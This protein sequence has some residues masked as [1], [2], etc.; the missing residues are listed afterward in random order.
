[1]AR[2]IERGKGLVSR[3]DIVNALIVG[4]LILLPLLS[5][6]SGAAGAALSADDRKCLSCHAT[7][8]LAKNLANGENLPLHV[9]QDGFAKSVHANL[10]C[11]G[12]HYAIDL[13]SH[14]PGKQDVK[15]IRAYSVELSE[16]C[17]AC[18][19]GKFK[20]Y[21]GSIHAIL[22]RTGNLAAPVCTDCH[23]SHTVSKAQYE[24]L[25]GVPCKKCHEPIFQAYAGSMHG[26]ARSKP[27]H[28]EA[29][30]CADCHRSHDINPAAIGDRLRSVCLGCHAGALSA[31]EKWLPNAKRHLQ[32]VSCPAC[33]APAAQRQIDL[34]LVDTGARQAGASA[35]PASESQATPAASLDATKAGG[36]DALDAQQL[37]SL[38]R[39][40]NRSGAEARSTLQGKIVV[41][42]GV[43]AHRLAGKTQAV[44]DCESCHRAGADP[45]QNVTLSIVGPD[46][47]PVRYGAQQEVL[48]SIISVDSLGGF[49]AIG[50]T[51]IKLLDIV[52]VLAVLGGMAVPVLH[53]A[54][55]ALARRRLKRAAA[56]GPPQETEPR[57]AGDGPA[58]GKAQK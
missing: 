41:R 29:P 47:R 32:A 55:R 6:D 52:L 24:T 18:H 22:V 19:A 9:S 58:D 28:L 40:M 44:R 11:G 20:E 33:H 4:I 8:G 56:Q 13:K 26:Q 48:S 35:K 49:Y 2:A 57:P 15:S 7:Q 30:I 14:P 27:G 51:R 16:V 54:I 37:W 12:C 1:M 36:K 31:H 43:D 50:G 17:R 21:E 10:G 53:L 42:T 5:P 23:G 25:A 38:L 3:A 39:E 45:F 46:G 34:R